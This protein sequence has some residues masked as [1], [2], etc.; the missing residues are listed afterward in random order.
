MRACPVCRRLVHGE[1]LRELADRAARAERDADLTAELATW[2]EALELLPPG[3]RQA[4]TIRARI[5]RLGRDVD[6]APRGRRGA[7]SKTIAGAGGLALL[8]W[9]LKAV[10]AFAITKGKALLLGFTNLGML[11]GVL[12]SFGVYWAAW[13]WKFAAGLVASLWVHEMGHVVALRRFGIRASAPAFIPGLGALVRLEQ[14]PSNA[15]ENARIGLAGPIWGTAAALVALAAS[16]LLDW[17]SFAAI[18]RFGAWLNLFNLLPFGPLD[19]G[20]GYGAL[21]RRQRWIATGV[22]GIAWFVTAEGLLGILTIVS[23]VRAFGHAEPRGD[24]RTLLEYSILVVIL[25]ALCEIEVLP[26]AP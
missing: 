8:L 25:A 2:R 11:A 24:R 18:A 15:L 19:G 5:E 6:A 17:P 22:L 23:V 10:A 13:G 26:G 20:R 9:K 21:D 4:E 3:T 1:R 7:W 16:V 14:Y 12:A